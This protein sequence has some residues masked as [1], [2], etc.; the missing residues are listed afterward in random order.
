LFETLDASQ[1]ELGEKEKE[2]VKNLLNKGI[3]AS[4]LLASTSNASSKNNSSN[5][6]TSG[7]TSLASQPVIGSSTAASFATE[8]SPR[9]DKDR[10]KEK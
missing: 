1:T 9:K 2:D 6:S 5:S 10:E 4:N 7:S 8:S 3:S